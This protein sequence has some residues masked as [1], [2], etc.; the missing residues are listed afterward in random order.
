MTVSMLPPVQLGAHLWRLRWT[1]DVEAPTYR[2]YRDGVLM[3]TQTGQ[4]L[5]LAVGDDE[6]PMIEVLDDPDANPA[7]AWPSRLTVCWYA[8]AGAEHYRIEEQVSGSWVLRARVRDRGQGY[9]AWRT[10][11]LEDSATHSFRIVAVA[12][13][14]QQSQATALSAL[15]VR[16][17]DAP[18]VRFSYDAD[19]RKVTI[20]A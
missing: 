13:N 10:R 15:M 11:V 7:R 6:S 2:V 5:D 12:E 17:P 18:A 3:A 4:T 1:S 20:T 9:F 8:T 14:G 19:T 16:H